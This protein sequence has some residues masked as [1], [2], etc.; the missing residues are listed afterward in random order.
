[1]FIKNTITMY[2]LQIT[3]NIGK[4]AELKTIK[5]KSYAEYSVAV[6]KGKDL[7]EWVKCFKLDE[8]GKLYK[9]LLKGIKVYCEGQPSVS[10]YTK[11]GKIIGS[12]SLFVNDLEFLSK[13]EKKEVEAKQE[14][15]EISDDLPFI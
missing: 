4:N 7:T 12:L 11:E 15:F 10:G 8:N 1:M 14:E 5:G 13:S 6:S 9:Y 2:K 3:G